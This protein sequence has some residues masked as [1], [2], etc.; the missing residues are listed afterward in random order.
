MSVKRE[1]KIKSLKW[2]YRCRKERESATYAG[3]EE[4]MDNGGVE[5]VSH[6]KTLLKKKNLSLG[7]GV[8]VGFF[9]R[10]KPQCSSR[11]RVT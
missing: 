11:K 4:K 8:K 7:S 9:M 5:G 3:K 10:E 1:R 6:G 2:Y